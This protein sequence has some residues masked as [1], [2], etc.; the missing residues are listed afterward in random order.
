MAAAGLIPVVGWA[1]RAFKGGEAIYKTARGISAAE[2]A[3]DAYKTTAKSLEMLKNTERGMYGLITANGMGE[4]VIG[5]DMFGNKLT[6]EQ[7]KDSFIEALTMTGFGGAAHY[8]DR[9][10]A[11]NVPPELKPLKGKLEHWAPQNV[12]QYTDEMVKKYA[13]NMVENPGPLL[14]VNPGAAA[15]F[16]SGMYNVT[17]LKEDT[18]L[19]RLGK[20]GGGRN[21]FGQYFTREPSTRIEG[22]IDLAVKPQWIDP[23]TGA[24]TGSSPLESVY[25]LKI[26]ADTTIYEG[27]AGY[28]AGIYSGGGNQIFI[29]KPWEI[30]GVKVIPETPLQ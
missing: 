21:A 12:N 18:I 6:D 17:K 14:D 29:S 10:H 2:H 25:T 19:Y 4:A 22:R 15:T 26:P 30:K 13:F 24:L 16:R 5:R 8:V 3:L 9:L 20:A 1:G 27:P 7:R 28:Q 11:R 23:R